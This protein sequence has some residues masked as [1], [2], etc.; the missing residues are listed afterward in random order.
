L[1][2]DFSAFLVRVDGRV[3]RMSRMELQLLR[4]LIRHADEVVSREPIAE[5]V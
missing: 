1:T 5:S 3:I 4:F 2:A